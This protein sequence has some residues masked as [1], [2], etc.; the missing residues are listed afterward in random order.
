[1][2]KA[3]QGGEQWRAGNIYGQQEN[4][5]GTVPGRPD[6]GSVGSWPGGSRKHGDSGRVRPGLQRTGSD[7]LHS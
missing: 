4:L 6:P 7:C 1:M 3:G 5:T 2:L